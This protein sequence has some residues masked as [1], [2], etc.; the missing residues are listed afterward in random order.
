MF[1]NNEIYTLLSKQEACTQ[2]FANKQF[3][4]ADPTSP[5][6][7]TDV[8][9][10]K[11]SGGSVVYRTFNDGGLNTT[12]ERS[13]LKITEI[14]LSD[15]TADVTPLAGAADPNFHI[16]TAKVKVD[17]EKVD[18]NSSGGSA[19]FSREFKIVVRLL[20]TG[21][22]VLGV[23]TVAADDKKIQ[24]C[25]ATGGSGASDGYWQ[26]TA[27]MEYII[28]KRLVSEQRRPYIRSMLWA[29]TQVARD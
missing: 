8:D 9:Q 27:A 1:L 10:I 17:F 28:T 2:T 12:Y 15:Y 13:S 6:V 4:Y 24:F 26:P 3:S 29:R 23:P 14:T 11:N 7:Y 25:Y 21:V 19:I 5:T 22:P 20:Q 16:G 18:Q